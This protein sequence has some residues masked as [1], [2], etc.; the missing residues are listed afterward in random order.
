MTR[1]VAF[2]C[3]NT[4]GQ[5]LPDVWDHENKKHTWL[6]EG[7]LTPSKYAWPQF[8]A[9]K[10]NRECSNY[11]VPAASAKEI[12]YRII[13]TNF[14][15]TD[16]VTI[17]WPMSARFCLLKK[18]ENSDDD[19][20]CVSDIGNNEK[21]F[22]IGHWDWLLKNKIV[23]TYYK[24]IYDRHDYAIDTYMRINYIDMFLKDKVNITIHHTTSTLF[25]RSL[26]NTEKESGLKF[27]WH[28]AKIS[29]PI[30]EKTI[31]NHKKAL[32]N[33]HPGKEAH[34]A[35]AIVIYNEIKNNLC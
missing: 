32:D 16:I 35:F 33:S 6:M 9:N 12:W 19:I 17:L 18:E 22:R 27:K 5:A 26:Y 11:G 7:P 15:K 8:V 25:D 23:N 30:F 4:F 13:N 28:T 1:L 10:L 20:K 2:G 21:V 24:F 14:I 29:D 34:K 31:S 3:S